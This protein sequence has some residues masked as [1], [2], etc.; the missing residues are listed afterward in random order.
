MGLEDQMLGIVVRKERPDLQQQKDALMAQ[1]AEM[2]RQLK[3]VEDKILQ[4]LAASEGDVLEDDLLVNTIADAK[5]TANEITE[6]QKEAAINEAEI[7][8]TREGYRAVAARA[9][10]LFFCITELASIDPMYQFSLQWFQLLFEAGVEQT[11]KS[12]I[13]EQRLENLKHH[14]TELLYAN[15]CRGLFVRHKVLFS[16]AMC[17]QLLTAAGELDQDEFKKN[18]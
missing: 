14:F 16:F 4:L 12:D 7:D 3:N 8:R 11:E 15:V 10:V 5:Q 1:N 13:P 9:Q 2:N 17:A 18:H 6:K